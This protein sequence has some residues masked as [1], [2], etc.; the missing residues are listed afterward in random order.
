MHL[1]LLKRFPLFLWPLCLISA[2]TQAGEGG[3]SFR[4]AC[5][6]VCGGGRCRQISLACVGN[7]RSVPATL[8]L[9]PLA[10]VCFPGLK[11]SGSRLLSRERALSCVHFPGL[12]LS[13]SGF[14]VL[15][16]STDATGPA[17]C[18]FPTRAAQAARSLMSTL[19]LGAGRLIPSAVPACFQARWSGAPCV[20]SGKLISGCNPPSGC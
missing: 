8:G 14:R 5:S 16:K 6:V 10:A 1:S 3:L 9:P 19:S 2:L 20:C 18:A 12:S 4:F 15:H 7:T 13:D 11:R 17:F